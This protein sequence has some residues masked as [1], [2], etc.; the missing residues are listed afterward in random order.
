MKTI[1]TSLLFVLCV[2]FIQ[3][4]KKADQWQENLLDSKHSQTL[5]S[6]SYGSDNRNQMDIALPKNRTTST[7]V[8][9]LIHGGAWVFGDKSY[10]ASD[11]Q[12]FADE[13]IACATINYRF[14][15]DK[16][17]LHNDEIVSDVRMAI[18][19][20]ISK[21]ESWQISPERFGIS[22]HSAG[23][24]LALLTAYTKNED[25]KIKAC[26][27]WAGPFDLIDD[28]QL[29]ITGSNELFK[30]Y[31]GH[32]LQSSADTVLYKEA[33]PYWMLNNNSVPTLLIHGT[34]DPGVPHSNAVKMKLKLDNLGVQ[35]YF[36]SMEGAYHIWTG[37]HLKQARSTTLNWFKTKL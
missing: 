31:V 1:K 23:G 16:K 28:D 18:D 29:K 20:I 19:F 25:G 8:V 24:N 22:G 30:L 9:V 13:G 5:Y 35:N 2:L 37:E 27:S 36:L 15:S 11:I 10:F 14:A 4:C 26:G 21:S 3:S 6:I 17:G 34:L 12:K 7:P 33:S 32:T